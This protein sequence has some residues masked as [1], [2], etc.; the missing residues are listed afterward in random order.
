MRRKDDVAR[1]IMAEELAAVRQRLG[2]STKASGSIIDTKQEHVSVQVLS[3][4]LGFH[5]INP[6]PMC[7]P[8]DTLHHDSSC[9][10]YWCAVVSFFTRKRLVRVLDSF[11]R[12]PP[13][14][15]SQQ[16]RYRSET[17]TWDRLK[18]SSV[19]SNEGALPVLEGDTHGQHK[20]VRGQAVTVATTDSQD[21]SEKEVID[22]SG[23]G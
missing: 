8:E 15:P 17:P 13:H 23:H 20:R 2:A 10:R 14:M 19:P 16:P 5:V 11:P 12:V 18:V 6:D 3:G 9:Q 22:S 1:E 7:P 4:R 21:F